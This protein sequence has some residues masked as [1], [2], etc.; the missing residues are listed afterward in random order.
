M[1]LDI[2][3]KWNIYYYSLA[4]LAIRKWKVEGKS[5]NVPAYF[6]SDWDGLEWN[7]VSFTIYKFWPSVSVTMSKWSELE[8]LINVNGTI[9]KYS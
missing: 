3:S 2:I 6:Q 4:G 1:I 8:V 5:G 9:L 7:L